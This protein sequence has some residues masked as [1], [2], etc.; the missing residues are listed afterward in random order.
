LA[1][2]VTTIINKDAIIMNILPSQYGFNV[3]GG[4]EALIEAVQR[5]HEYVQQHRKLF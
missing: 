1:S 5:Q 3:K 4:Q 2:N